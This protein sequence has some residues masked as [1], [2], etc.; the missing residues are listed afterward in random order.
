MVD[1]VKHHARIRGLNKGVL[2]VEVDSSALLAELQGFM[3]DE[4]VDRLNEYLAGPIVR[5][6]RVRLGSL[7]K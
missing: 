1:N 2:L 4:I 7:E 5:T 3:R 6:F